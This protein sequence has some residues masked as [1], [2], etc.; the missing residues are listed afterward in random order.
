MLIQ[1]EYKPELFLKIFGEYNTDTLHPD[2]TWIQR[3]R[4][5]AWDAAIELVMLRQPLQ[6]PIL[7]TKPKEI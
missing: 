6:Q 4:A 5:S 7:T 2:W 1:P 3:E